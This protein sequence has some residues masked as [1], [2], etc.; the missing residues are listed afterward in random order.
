MLT[1]M[2]G[3][4]L[5]CNMIKASTEAFMYVFEEREGLQYFFFFMLSAAAPSHQETGTTLKTDAQDKSRP[6]Q[7]TG[8]Q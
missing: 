6:V 4:G 1:C 8:V 5:M 3:A 2:N 7:H